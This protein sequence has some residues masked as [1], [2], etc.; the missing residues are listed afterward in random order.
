MMS[1]V[2]ERATQMLCGRKPR[3]LPADSHERRLASCSGATPA[4]GHLENGSPRWFDGGWNR[5]SLARRPRVRRAPK[6]ACA[7]SARTQ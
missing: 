7:Q 1:S 6:V 3:G 4:E 5:G 2:P